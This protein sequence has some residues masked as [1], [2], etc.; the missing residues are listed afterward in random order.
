[1]T[2]STE[3]S[4]SRWHQGQP[5]EPA[6]RDPRRS[7]RASERACSASR[8]LCRATWRKRWR[9]IVDGCAGRRPLLRAGRCSLSK[10]GHTLAALATGGYIV[11]T[12]PHGALLGVVTALAGRLPDT[13]EGVTGFGSA[14]ER[15]SLIP[16]RTISHSP[17]PWAALI[18][19]GLLLPKLAT[20][21]GLLAVGEV[22][23]GIGAGAL[24]HLIL[25]LFSPTG[26]PLANPFGRRTSLGP[27]R[28]G[29]RRAYLYRTSPP[30]EWPLLLAFI[31]LLAAESALVGW[32]L[33][34]LGDPNLASVIRAAI[35]GR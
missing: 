20:P 4:S 1:M 22:L 13:I 14:G 16:H 24:V 32:R 7:G 26:I 27:Y 18:M 9:R 12:V 29:G 17:W 31:A 25:D 8:A 2:S 35:A 3:P 30:E 6:G 34:L 21:A 5:D 23:A 11:L 15:R 19:V 33:F 28:S 10:H